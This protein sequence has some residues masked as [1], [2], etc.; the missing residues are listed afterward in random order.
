MTGKD[1]S[2]LSELVQERGSNLVEE[3]VPVSVKVGVTVDL[4][5]RGGEEISVPIEPCGPVVSGLRM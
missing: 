3:V 1:D 5:V 4:P 2:L